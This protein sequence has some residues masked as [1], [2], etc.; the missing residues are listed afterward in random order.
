MH[1]ALPTIEKRIQYQTVDVTDL[2]KEGDNELFFMLADGWYRGSV[3]AWGMRNYYGSETKLL[4][5][6]EI[7]Y[8]DGE[9]AV[10]ATDD[11]FSWTQDGPIRFADNKDGEI[12]DAGR[13]DFAKAVW[14]KQSDIAQDM[15]DGFQQ[16]S[17]DRAGAADESQTDRDAIRGKKV[18]DFGQNIAGILAF[19]VKNAKA[20]QRIFLRFGELMKDGEFTQKNI[21]CARGEFKTP[22]QQVEYFCKEGR[23]EYKTTF[24]IFGYQ[25]IEVEA[26]CPIDP[27]NFKAIAVYSDF[28]TTFTFDS[29]NALLNQFVKNTLWSLKNNSADLPT[30]CPTRERHGWSGDAQIFVNTAS[31]M[32]NYAPF[33]L[34]YENDLCDWQDKSG[35]FPQIAPEGGTDFLYACDEWICR[36]VGCRYSDSLSS[37]EDVWG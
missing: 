19:T 14:K 32:V 1:R 34:K 7:T 33:A 25:Y 22:L 3:G 8:E 17:I 16:F 12:Y 37:M 20:G 36:L 23:N 35:N 31:Y 18:L 9:V 13:E 15:A 29:S 6:I 21:Q 4:A 30:D 24:A 5:Q 28:E 11:T 2:L 27:T 26:D 10:I